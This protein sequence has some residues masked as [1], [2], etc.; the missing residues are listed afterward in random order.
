MKK[1]LVTG[2]AGF[3]G[4]NLVDALVKRGDQVTVLDDMT[5][6]KRANLAE[7]EKSGK[8]QVIEGSILDMDLVR[9]C[10]ADVDVILHLAVACLRVCFDKP[11]HVHEVNATGTLNLLEAAQ[12][13]GKPLQRF[14]YCSSSEVYGTAMHAP[15]SE[16]HPL[17]PTTV[18]GASKLAGELYTHAYHLTYGMPT[19]IL[20]PFNTYGFREHH[21]G[22][23][24]E[25][26]PRFVV[27]IVNGQP[28]M[29]FGDGTQTRDFT[30]VTDTVAG[31][32]AA[33]EH[34]GLLGQTINLARGQE[35][36]VKE[37]ADRLLKL[38][39]RE[40][41]GITWEAERPAD[42]Q[43]HYADVRKAKELCGFTAGIGI[44]EGLG[45]YI[46]WF[47]QTYPDPAQLLAE[48]ETF[49]WKLTT[50]VR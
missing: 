45:K 38:L 12:Q 34:D 33:S 29:I 25:V 7:A 14:A 39:G 27:R 6:G 28:P 32:I 40:D 3:I 43:R 26:I 49:N 11:H 31:I 9:K 2:G 48:M 46:E 41:L 22:A 4:S 47:R 18:Y 42:V 1:I 17:I 50:P 35:V 13:R 16:D 23:S 21:E 20:R 15:M 8:C 30:F 5:V 10:V 19:V 36:T 24:G 37:I 44:E